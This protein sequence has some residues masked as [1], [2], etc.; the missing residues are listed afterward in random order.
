MTSDV[1][2]AMTKPTNVQIIQWGLPEAAFKDRHALIQIARIFGSITIEVETMTPGS[3]QAAAEACRFVGRFGPMPSIVLQWSP[4]HNCEAIPDR[5]PSEGAPTIYCAPFWDEMRRFFSWMSMLR[6][7]APGIPVTAFIV[8]HEQIKVSVDNDEWNANL[9]L[10]H[11]ILDYHITSNKHDDIP[12][13]VYMLGD[14]GQFNL[15]D[16]PGN[17]GTRLY[18]PFAPGDQ[19][20]RINGWNTNSKYA[21]DCAVFVAI[22]CGYEGPPEDQG[23]WNNHLVVTDEH[24]GRL[25]AAFAGGPATVILYPS[26]L[27]TDVCDPIECFAAFAEGAAP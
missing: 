4:L 20:R 22:G 23:P 2:A 5:W 12:R 13:Y 15:P 7:H 11:R 3:V 27:N 25:G 24:Y 14:S 1:L 19:L 16:T 18:H 8:D 10:M 9:L 26:I 6:N 17:K 21:D